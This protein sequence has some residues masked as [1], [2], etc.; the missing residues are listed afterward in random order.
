MRRVGID[1]MG[2]Y[3][4][5]LCVRTRDL[6]PVRG[7][8]VDK[9]EKGLGILSFAVPLPCEDAVTMAANALD[10][11]FAQGRAR[12]DEIAR[13]VVATESAHDAAKPL[14]AW[15]HGMFRLR[16]DC[17]AFEVK[18]ACVAGPIALI[19]ALRF[20]RDTGSKAV[21]ITT[22]IA[23]YGPHGSAEFTQGAAAVALLVAPDPALLTLDPDTTGI[24]SSDER[25]FYRPAGR[26]E[27]V[28]HGR[29]SVQCYLQA[30]A[31][32]DDFRKRNS[33]R[34]IFSDP[35]PLTPLDLVVFHTPY[36]A[37]PRKACRLLLDQEPVEPAR[38][39]RLELALEHSLRPAARLG[40]THTSAVFL[41]L[42]SA[43]AGL[44]PD[45]LGR[46]AALF[47]YGSGSSARFCAGTVGHDPAVLDPLR[48]APLALNSLTPVSV[49]DYETLFYRRE[50]PASGFPCRGWRIAR[51]DE[52]G[53]RHYERA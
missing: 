9:V 49:A 7:E 36:P 33:V 48:T 23:V 42:A 17:E 29:L 5:S 25:D 10:G 41:A 45:A 15:L 31:A 2:F 35:G 12:P 1:A 52:T 11:L 40:N 43:L 21:V 22:D 8:S 51:I 53:Y 28:V 6:A 3:W 34:R 18:F 26:A 30:L 50:L 16:P 39:A 38:R 24:Y 37:L 13:L 27:A 19:D 46:K 47:T 20:V 4:P 44:G 14:A 32:V